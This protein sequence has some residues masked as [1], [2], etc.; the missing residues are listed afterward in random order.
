MWDAF[1]I[2]HIKKHNVTIQEVE[3]A[4]RNVIDHKKA[5][6]GRYAV[7]TKLKNRLLTLIVKRKGVGVYYIVTAR[8]TAKKERRRFYE[9]K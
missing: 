2:E 4:T 3:E 7:F 1:N 9:K 6:Y 5:R 8:D